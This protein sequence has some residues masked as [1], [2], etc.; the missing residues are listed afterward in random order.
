MMIFDL[1]YFNFLKLKLNHRKKY[2]N[3]YWDHYFH[4]QSTKFGTFT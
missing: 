1:K 3:L 4:T 2:L